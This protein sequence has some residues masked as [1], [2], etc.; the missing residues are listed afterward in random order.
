MDGQEAGGQI[1]RDEGR[2]M[3][4]VIKLFMMG[5][6]ALGILAIVVYLIVM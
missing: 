2:I 5:L 3:P 1:R 4:G 6:V